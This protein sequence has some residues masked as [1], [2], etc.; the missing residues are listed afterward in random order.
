MTVAQDP[1][2]MV[3]AASNNAGNGV[4]LGGG[5]YGPVWA[6]PERAVLVLGPPRAGKTSSIIIPAVLAAN[7]PV[8]S[9]STKHDVMTFTAQARGRAGETLLYDPSGTVERPRGVAALAWS[10]ISTCSQWDEALLAARLMVASSVGGSVGAR[11]LANGLDNHW[12]ERSSALLAALLHSASLEGAPMSTVLRWVDRHQAGP[13]QSILDQAGNELAGDLLGGI[14]TTDQRELSGIW[15][16]TSGVLNAYHSNAAMTSTTGQAFDPAAWCETNGT[17]Y[18]CA[19][20]HHQELVSP[21]VV[22]LL[23]EIRTATFLRDA[24]L[25]ASRN[26][27]VAPMTPGARGDSPLL[28]ALDEL[29]NIAPLPDLQKNLGEGGG[30]GLITLA[31]LQD[32]SQARARWGP[33]A[34]GWLSLFGA[35]II[36]RGIEDVKT[37]EMVSVLAGEEEVETRSVSSPVHTREGPMMSAL[38][39]LGRRQAP[40]TPK[41]TVTTSTVRRRRMPVDEISRGKEGMALIIDESTTMNYVG[42]TPFFS[43]EPW[44]SIVNQ[45]PKLGLSAQGPGLPPPGGRW[46]R[47]NGRSDP[48]PPQPGLEFG[49]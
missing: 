29:A 40:E 34:D 1:L 11:Q 3:R 9:T 5:I 20:A 28:F 48:E 23:S 21:L 32:M 44:L 24:N 19:S 27:G 6:T 14:A 22:A 41:P 30:Q 2:A 15:S 37:L 36:L 26:T 7:G 38:R 46:S 33:E 16:T 8:V 17:I 35:K 47:G 25:K 31:C 39:W 45:G 10:P 13:A 42:L 49:T 4:Y 18:I 12:H 43:E